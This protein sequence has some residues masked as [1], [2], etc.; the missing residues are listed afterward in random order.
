MS[1]STWSLSVGERRLVQI[2]AAL[3]TP[4]SRVLIDE[5]TCGL[6][7]WKVSQVSH[8]LA[9]L[10]QIV[11]L[12]VATQDPRIPGLIGANTLKLGE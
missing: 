12:V 9:Q 4:A 3:M 11:P 5:P 8:L 1:R 2:A 6:D 7:L 10:G